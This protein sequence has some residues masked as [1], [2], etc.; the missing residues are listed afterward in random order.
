MTKEDRKSLECLRK[1]FAEGE[2]LYILPSLRTIQGF[3]TNSVMVLSELLWT[4]IHQK[5]SGEWF[6]IGVEELS[7][8]LVMKRDAQLRTM[9]NLKLKGFIEVRKKGFPPER[10]V[11]VD[12]DAIGEAMG[13]RL[14]P[15]E[16]KK[17]V[18]SPF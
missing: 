3:R 4:A 7:R 13:C 8:R 18:S 2:K 11:R 14:N 6:S 12:L 15:E 16:L 10:Q 9:K 1:Y 17:N 5:D